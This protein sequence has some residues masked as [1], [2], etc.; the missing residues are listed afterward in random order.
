MLD[1]CTLDSDTGRRRT[2][3]TPRKCRP[4][5]KR[6]Y[7]RSPS[8]APVLLFN[9]MF[10]GQDQDQ[11]SRYTNKDEDE[12]GT[13]MKTRHTNTDGGTRISTRIWKRTSHT[14]KDG[15]ENKAHAVHHL[16]HLRPIVHISL[17][18]PSPIDLLFPPS[19]A[20]ERACVAAKPAT[21]PPIHH[22]IY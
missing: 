8:C 18:F 16:A 3:Y 9:C 20:S 11:D 4:G 2:T 15:N 13:G 10:G 12:D 19:R 14:N 22:P 7:V 1:A 17:L 5:R 6:R 21:P